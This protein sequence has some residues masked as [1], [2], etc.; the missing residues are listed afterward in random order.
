MDNASV[1]ELLQKYSKWS[2]AKI[3]S[4]K[5]HRVSHEIPCLRK[6]ELMAVDDPSEMSG[7]DLHGNGPL[8]PCESKSIFRS[9]AHHLRAMPPCPTTCSL[10]APL[11]RAFPPLQSSLLGHA[12]GSSFRDCFVM[13]LFLASLTYVAGSFLTR[14]V[15]HVFYLFFWEERKNRISISLQRSGGDSSYHSLCK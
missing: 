14:C 9:R 15:Y 3:H 2:I 6:L 10:R 11:C 12:C 8:R 7:R 5:K 4:G 1:R 13:S